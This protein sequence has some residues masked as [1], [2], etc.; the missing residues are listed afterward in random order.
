MMMLEECEMSGR[1]RRAA[2]DLND[3]RLER[4]LFI[5]WVFLMDFEAAISSWK[6]KGKYFFS[7]LNGVSNTAKSDTTLFSLIDLPV[8]QHLASI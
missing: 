8:E 2:N 5:F 4:T 6:W 3:V 7:I 1:K